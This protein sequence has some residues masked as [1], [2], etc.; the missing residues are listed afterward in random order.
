LVGLFTIGK[1]R[2]ILLDWHRGNHWMGMERKVDG[3]GE[4]EVRTLYSVLLSSFTLWAGLCLAFF[5]FYGD[6]DLLLARLMV[7]GRRAGR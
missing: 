3:A 6:D 1:K 4:G 2:R 7:I 5:F